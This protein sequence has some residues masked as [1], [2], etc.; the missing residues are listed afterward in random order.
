MVRLK[1]QQLTK[2]Y[3]N[4][5]KALDGIT[6][7]I[8]NGMFGL[9]G[10]NGAGKSSLMRTL[11]T[12]QLPDAG[13]VHFDGSDVLQNSQE[14]RNKLGY[15]PQ[16]FGVYPKVS[17]IDLLNHL[18]VLKGLQNKNERKEQVT[19]LL[20]Q[21]NLF[22]V[23]KR[24]VSTF[25]G[26]MRQRFGIAQALLGNPQLI[27]VDEPTAGLD[28]QERNRF[29][30]L[31]SE[32]GANRVVILSTHIVEDVNDLCAEMAVMANGKLILQ[33]KPSDLT[34]KLDGKIW[35]RVIDKADLAQYSSVFNVIS[36][37]IISGKLHIFIL[38]DECPAHVFERVYPRL[39][40][41]Y[42]S[43]LFGA[44]NQNLEVML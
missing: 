41:V 21:T 43:S 32:I 44:A 35:R 10:P 13:Q 14:M 11:A 5:V 26:G 19:S 29:H 22:E 28:P 2:S 38:A 17:A 30:D 36:T 23:R 42:F 25:S 16:D 31:L 24:Y 27:I 20:Q 37:K 33:G 40:E 3:Q 7:N 39:E 12:L 9:L 34:Q 15:L 8:A 6:L 1:I 18:A 4:G